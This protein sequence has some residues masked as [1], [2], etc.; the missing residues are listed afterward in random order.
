MR[1]MRIFQPGAYISMDFLKKKSDV[2]RI[3]NEMPST[4]GETN[5][6]EIEL[7]DSSKKYITYETAE[8]KEV[9]AI[10]ME[11]ELF[12]K[13]IAQDKPVPVSVY[14]GYHAMHVAQQI[15]DKIN[16]QLITKV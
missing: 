6:F 5:H 4:N 11:L 13:A 1:K 12:H 9:N 16:A 2:F 7:P 14:D 8:K 15:A 10:K 3:E